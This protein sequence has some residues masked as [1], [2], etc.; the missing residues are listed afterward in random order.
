M[1]YN[2]EYIEVITYW[3]RQL[4]LKGGDWGKSHTDDPD[5]KK[6]VTTLSILDPP[7]EGFEPV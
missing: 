5:H 4:L 1:G 3:P 7:M 6:K 2:L